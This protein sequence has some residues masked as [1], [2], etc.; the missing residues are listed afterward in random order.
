M[1]RSYKIISKNDLGRFLQN[2][3]L[4]FL[5]KDNKKSGLPKLL[6]SPSYA[7]RQGVERCTVELDPVGTGSRAASVAVFST[8]AGASPF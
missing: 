1:Y 4:I 5:K 6:A 2:K 7:E 3:T 8:R